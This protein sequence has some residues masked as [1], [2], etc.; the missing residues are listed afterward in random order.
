MLV[1]IDESGDTGRKIQKGSSEYFVIVLVT[2]EEHEDAVN[3]DQR[4]ALLREEL[5]LPKNYEFK[6]NKMRREQRELFLKA[7]L[8]YSFFYFGVIINKDPKKLYG[9]GFNIKESFYKYTCSLVF[10]NA[11]PYLK[12][13]IVIID[14]SGSR[15]FKF[16]LQSYLKKKIGSDLIRKVKMQ[17]SHSNNLVQLADMIAGSV[18]RSLSKKGDK[19][20]YRPIIKSREM[21]VQIWPSKNG[22]K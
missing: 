9:E 10:E 21:S 12:D 19:H 15:E 13:A 2:F 7:V 5:H 16:Q 3:C 22:S 20:I 6:F 18:H 1:F 8:P 11:K 14:G 4:I 17:S